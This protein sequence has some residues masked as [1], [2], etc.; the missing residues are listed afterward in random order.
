MTDD[1]A[2]QLAFHQYG[3]L[4]SQ[5]SGSVRDARS[6][7]ENFTSTP[8]STRD[9]GSAFMSQYDFS[10]DRG[11]S[12]ASDFGC[13]LGCAVSFVSGFDFERS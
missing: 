3:I 4:P 9:S 12:S 7:I 5:G 6:S 1:I 10:N 13:V 11:A 8:F 2:S